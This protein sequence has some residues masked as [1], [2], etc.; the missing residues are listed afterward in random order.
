MIWSFGAHG[1]PKNLWWACNESTFSWN[2]S[3]NV[4]AYVI[5]ELNAMFMYHVLSSYDCFSKEL[6][7]TPR[8]ILGTCNSWHPTQTWDNWLRTPLKDWL[9][10]LFKNLDNVWCFMNE[11]CK[12]KG[13]NNG[14]KRL[15]CYMEGIS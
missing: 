12:C 11:K 8:T 1:C 14:G 5:I 9:E 3:T 13:N 2:L 15:W 10:K 6:F 7:F 4:E